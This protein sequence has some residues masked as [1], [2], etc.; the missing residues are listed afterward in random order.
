MTWLRTKEEIGHDRSKRDSQDID[1]GHNSR[2]PANMTVCEGPDQKRVTN[3]LIA[4]SIVQSG[5]VQ[6][7]IKRYAVIGRTV[8]AVAVIDDQMVPW[9]RLSRSQLG[10][11]GE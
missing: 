4:V 8:L 10:H 5:V 6:Q 9:Q 2:I 11:I 3:A 1:R 7:W